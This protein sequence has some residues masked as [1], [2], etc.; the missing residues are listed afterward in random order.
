MIPDYLK[1]P[2]QFSGRKW[3]TIKQSHDKKSWVI[4]GHPYMITMAKR[5]FPGSWGKRDRGYIRFPISK[6][7]V[8][9]LNWFMMRFP[10]KVKN[11][12]AWMELLNGA[13]EHFEKQEKIR[14]TKVKANPSST[15]I[16]EL[17]EFQKEGLA[18][19]LHNSRSLLADQMGLGKTPTALAWLTSLK[20]SPPYILV[21]PPHIMRQWDSEIRKFLSPSIRTH[22][23]HGLKPYSLP[24]AD[25]FIIHYLLLRGW[26]AELPE[27]GFSACV[28]DEIQELRRRTSEKYS[29]ASL[30]SESC[31]HAIG[32]S[33]TP[34][35]NYGDEMWSVMNILQYKCLGDLESF[36]REWCYY[37]PDGGRWDNVT[38]K[39]PGIF[40]D[41]LRTE[42]LMLRRRKEEVMNELPP[43]RRIVQNIDVNQGVFDELIAPAVEQALNI[44]KIKDPWERGKQS[45]EAIDVARMATG[46]AKAHF[47]CAFVKMLMEAGEAV[48]LYAH[49]HKVIDI[50]LEELKEYYPVIISG[51]QNQKQKDESQQEFMKG[52]TDL[53]IVSLRSGTGL[54]LQRARCVVF[55]ELDW[56]PACHTQCEDRAHR[57][58][59]K[60]SVLC[61]Y[62]TCNYGT[63]QDMMETLGLKTSQFLSIMGDRIETEEDKM[64]AQATM[65]EHMNRIIKTLQGGGKKKPS[66]ITE[67]AEKI[68]NL[69]R[70]PR[71]IEPTSLEDFYQR[72]G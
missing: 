59:V 30:L 57:I 26:K 63:D 18:F 10:L 33:G 16:G 69:E 35:F 31:E 24:D 21:V 38:I 66:P 15:F 11:K 28:F 4:E 54:N 70:M 62:L 29:A 52:N 17:K 55:G 65:K 7:Y 19:L 9:D 39:E 14:K 3:G 47:V 67:V 27:Y 8:G 51:R 36:I 58:G 44:P 6:R 45:M 48:L 50:F 46:I 40:G 20:C 23:I 2:E 49:H 71:K 37:D 22:M 34:F 53:I 56:S 72:V 5:L 43:K 25:I 12:E 68:R 64:L 60:D 42:G 32:L 13:Q 1:P 61:Y 41:F